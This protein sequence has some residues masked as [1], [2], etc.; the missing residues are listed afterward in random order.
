MN[1]SLGINKLCAWSFHESETQHKLQKSE[2]D[3][4][5]NKSSSFVADSISK[6]NQRRM[7]NLSKLSVGLAA[8]VSE[9]HAID[10]VVFSSRYGE[11]ENSMQLVEAIVDKDLLS[12]M[13]FSQSVHNTS[14]GLYSILKDEHCAMEAISAGED[15]FVMGLVSAYAFL[16]TNL[17]SQVLYVYSDW[18]IPEVLRSMVNSS[19]HSANAVAMLLKAEDSGGIPIAIQKNLNSTCHELDDCKQFLTFV[20]EHFETSKSASL[21]TKKWTFRAL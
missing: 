14:S 1:I 5:W 21:N 19:Q 18:N 4:V 6:R 15:S 9:N 7:S 16:K 8:T 11:L 13:A 3:F 10:H 20:F 2:G 17:S 12:P